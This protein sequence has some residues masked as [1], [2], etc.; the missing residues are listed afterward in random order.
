[1]SKKIN[2]YIGLIA[3]L[4]FASMFY[5][6]FVE[7]VVCELSRVDLAIMEWANPVIS[8]SHAAIMGPLRV[9][10]TNPR[11]FMDGSGKAVR[12]AGHEIFVDLQDHS[13]GQQY[14][15]NWQ[16][17]LNWDWYLNFIEE[18]NFNYIRNWIYWSVEDGS[19]AVQPMMYARPGPGVAY[20]GLPKFDLNTFNQEFFDRMRSRIISA[21][22]RRVYISI[23][24][25]EVYGFK[26]GV[27]W[28]GNVF[29]GNNNINGINTVGDNGSGMGF[30][31]TSNP[32]VLK[33][34]KKIIRKII[35]TTND[36]DN[37]FYEVANE[38]FASEWQ[39]DI[40]EFIKNYEATKPK[41]HLV[42][43]SAGGRTKSFGWQ[44][45][46]QSQLINSGADCF[47]PNG[48]MLNPDNPVIYN[49]MPAIW[50][51]D[52]VWPNDWQNHKYAWISFTRGYHF[53]LYDAPFKNPEDENAEF[54]RF[55]YNVGGTAEYANKMDL[56]KMNPS[57]DSSD[58]STTYCLRNPGQE[59]LIYQPSS[60]SFK[61]NIQAGD[62]T[63]EWYRP[64]NHS[65]QSTGT[66]MAGGG[67]KSFTPPFS[68]EAVL[69]LKKT[70]DCN[71]PTIGI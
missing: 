68:G 2:T 69:Y 58:C 15:Y 9:H 63:Y 67:S 16:T 66:I 45:L 53:C 29:N 35:D 46:T 6:V 21:G 34:Q 39:Y 13:F 12:L 54:Q 60:G 42:Y 61:A 49:G 50:E 32:N 71:D 36:L 14:T 4:V 23:M 25:F 33:L 37:V 17:K 51:N 47:A 11:Y 38:S 28:N 26:S 56:A 55:R 40:I 24:L 64:S 65:I 8:E 3:I 43:M 31:Y 44:D 5:W 20:D 52:H 57:S 41:K 18:R 19:P 1:M 10:P 59:Y 70:S 30:F 22:K 27:R 62:Y 7:Y 48:K